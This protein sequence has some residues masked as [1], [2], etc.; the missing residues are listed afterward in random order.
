[1]EMQKHQDKC[2]VVDKPWSRGSTLRLPQIWRKKVRSILKFLTLKSLVIL[3]RDVKFQRI[4]DL[5]CF[6]KGLLD[7][8]CTLGEQTMRALV[9]GW[10][11]KWAC[12]T[13]ENESWRETALQ[14]LSGRVLVEVQAK[15]V[16][17]NVKE[18]TFQGKRRR[19]TKYCAHS[20]GLETRRQ[21]GQWLAQPQ[22]WISVRD[23]V[24]SE[25]DKRQ[26]CQ[27]WG[28]SELE[29]PADRS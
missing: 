21:S 6:S 11:Q 14:T 1:M 29:A 7:A 13:A 28:G 22:K 5:N 23:K 26:E 20:S 4:R 12:S 17:E 3:D 2:S 10:L 27:G 25:Q 8:V 24:D 19:K 15:P 18:F 9:T 16:G